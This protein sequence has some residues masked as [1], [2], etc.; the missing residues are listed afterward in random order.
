MK[1]TKQLNQNSEKDEKIEN[2]LRSEKK[3]PFEPDYNSGYPWQEQEQYPSLGDTLEGGATFI[4]GTE[5]DEK[6]KTPLKVITKDIII[7]ALQKVYDPEIPVSLY[8]LGLIY[9]IEIENN[10]NIKISMTLTTPNCP[11]A[12]TLPQMVAD[13]VAHCKGAGRVEVVLTWD[14]PWDTSLMSEDARLAMGFF[15]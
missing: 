12:G 1:N 5:L 15:D 2:I 9:S 6:S 4:S 3:P 13:Q 8:D 10:A 7:E 11:V 14:P